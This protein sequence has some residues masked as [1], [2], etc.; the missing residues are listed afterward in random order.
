MG[1]T[2]GVNW[3]SRYTLRPLSGMLS[4]V[5]SVMSWPI[6]ELVVL[7]RTASPATVT[8]SVI[9][10]GCNCRLTSVTRSTSTEMDSRTA[11]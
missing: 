2:P 9:S 3:T 11:F 1:T 6:V 4:S 10:P 7:A 8:D 5:L